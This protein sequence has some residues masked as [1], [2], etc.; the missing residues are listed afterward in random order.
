MLLG[1]VPQ[2]KQMDGMGMNSTAE[3]WSAAQQ[4]AEGA[5]P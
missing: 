4:E 5:G 2:D 1:L 3:C